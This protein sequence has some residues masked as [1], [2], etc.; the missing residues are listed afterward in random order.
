MIAWLASE[1][2][3]QSKREDYVRELQKYIDVDVYGECG[4]LK[5]GSRDL[6]TW[7]KDNCH[8]RL[9]HEKGSYKF[10]LSFENSLCKGYV[11][12][13]L[14][15][16]MS[17]DVVPIVM[18]LADYSN[19]LPKDSYIDVRDFPTPKALANY[20]KVLG[21]SPARYNQYIRNKNSLTCYLR[22]PYMPWE[23][24]L[25]ERLHKLRGSKSIVYDLAGFWGRSQCLTPK[26]FFSRSPNDDFTQ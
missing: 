8:Q 15:M 13:K 9:L 10:Y 11:T 26:Q 21:K 4:P 1:C 22:Y 14:W 24:L 7:E 3:T 20:L 2:A 6:I 16:L 23:C 12:E 18:G 5:C 25:C 19:M 17:M